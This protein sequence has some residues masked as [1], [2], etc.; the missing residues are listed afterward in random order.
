MLKETLRN[1]SRKPQ[2]LFWLVLAAFTAL[3]LPTLGL[4]RLM[5]WDELTHA[6][7]ALEAARDGHWM[8]LFFKGQ[9]WLEKPP[10]IP[11]L[12][13]LCIKL[14]GPSETA[15]RLPTFAFAALAV[16]LA[17]KLVA[18]VTKSLPAGLLAAFLLFCQPDLLFHARF[19]T[20]DSALLA[21]I[22]LALDLLLDAV[23]GPEPKAANRALC[24][25]LC[26]A[27]AVAAKSW[28]VLVFAPAGLVFLAQPPK[29]LSRA[30]LFWRLALPPALALLGW[31]ALYTWAYGPAF[32][33]EEWKVNTW[34]R[35][36]EWGKPVVPGASNIDFYT[37][38]GL[39]MAPGAL[40]L[41]LP[42]ALRLGLGRLKM[43]EP[44]QR[45]GSAFMLLFMLSWGLGALGIKHQVINY[46]LGFNF[47]A[48]L[49]AAQWMALEQSP[50]GLASLL[51]LALLALAASLLPSLLP[52]L[53]GLGLL[54]SLALAFAAA[55]GQAPGLPQPLLN[56]L[57]T[58]LLL[59]WALALLPAALATLWHPPDPNRPI[60][61][62][63]QAHPAAARGQEL[64]YAGRATQCTW[65]YSLYSQ[66][67]L[68]LPPAPL[69]SCAALWFDGS[70]WRFKPAA[71]PR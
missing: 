57:K 33:A 70:A 19:V 52:G 11:W 6:T 34:G 10:L 14:L 43:A 42:A 1:L 53:L 54:A 63:L 65:Y 59:L 51:L 16:A 35:A 5:D 22:L 36:V 56:R 27:L 46:M 9:P 13:A 37:Q 4:N 58:G 44:A 40:L 45:A 61:A 26:L 28:F 7:A 41:A 47:F 31:L 49:L 2:A 39:Q 32:L 17:A 48:C 66:R 21:C 68:D 8:P 62:L 60:V 55:R 25:G 3:V 20:M 30:G 38:W 67:P 15:A 18:R 69:P 50:W 29:G 12:T 64:A 24:A 71:P 23:E